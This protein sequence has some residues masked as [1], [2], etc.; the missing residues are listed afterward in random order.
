[1]GE[2]LAAHMTPAW[3]PAERGLLKVVAELAPS[4][5]DTLPWRL[6]YAEDS[7]TLSLFERVDRVLPHHDPL[8]RDRLIS[9]GAALT[10]VLI[11][12]RML[13][14][15]PRVRL[16][17]V[18]GRPHEAARV[19]V[20]T[21]R[22]PSEDEIARFVA[23]SY[24]RDHRAPFLEKPVGAATVRRL[25]VHGVDGVT[26]R[27][28]TGH[29]EADGAHPAGGAGVAVLPW[30]GPGRRSTGTDRRVWE[31][32]CVL[33]TPGDGPLDH[34][35]AGMA[36]ETMWLTAACDGLVCGVSTQPLQVPEVR[37][38]G[39]DA[40]SRTGFP[41]V[42]VRFGHP[43]RRHETL[44]PPGGDLGLSRHPAAAYDHGQRSS[45]STGRP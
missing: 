28:L 18:P 32:L 43:S 38:C 40:L 12:L 24:R 11:G 31:C 17:P 41:Q 22:A 33:E 1:M 14:W 36:L 4:V 9:C 10:N 13:D 3:A 27:W 44:G 45:W 34:L 8:G 21:R 29:R 19:D 35:R 39:V 6:V 37:A 30:A 7:R 5:H 2:A 42:V 20:R 25:T 26:V 23:V 16:L 15:V